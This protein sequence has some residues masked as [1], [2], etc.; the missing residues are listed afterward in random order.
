MVLGFETPNFKFCE[1]KLR[2]MTVGGSHRTPGFCLRDLTALS[3][4]VRS[5]KTL[6]EYRGHKSYVNSAVYTKDG[7]KVIS[8]S[9]DGD[10]RTISK[11]IV[12]QRRHTSRRHAAAGCAC[13]ACIERGRERE[14]D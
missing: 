13:I 9:S 1:L 2:E 3:L 6:K 10:R 7:S 5:G 4:T 12:C 14:R 8:A 11:H